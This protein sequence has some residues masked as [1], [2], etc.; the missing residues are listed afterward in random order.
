MV[1][2]VCRSISWEGAHARTEKSD[3][4]CNR[5]QLYPHHLEVLVPRVWELMNVGLEERV[6]LVC[7]S[8]CCT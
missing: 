7:G 1:R 8:V 2:L 3:L 5:L 6:V 4:Q